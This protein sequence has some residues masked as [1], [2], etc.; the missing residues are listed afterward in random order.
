VQIIAADGAESGLFAL[1]AKLDHTLGAYRPP[2]SG[3][4]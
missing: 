2:H 1:A 3:D 4:A